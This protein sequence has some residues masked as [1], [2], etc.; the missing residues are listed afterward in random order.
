MPRLGADPVRVSTS[1][2]EFAGFRFDPDRGLDR[3]GRAI[4]LARKEHRLLG[5]LL[6]ARGRVLTKEDIAR[7]VWEGARVSDD[8]IFRAV[9]VLRQTLARES[10]GIDPIAT[11]HGR[12]FR[13]SVPVGTSDAPSSSA[14]AN[15][16]RS[17]VPAAVES[18][19]LALE[20]RG[21]RSPEDMAIAVEAARRAVRID[22]GYVQAWSTLAELHIIDGTRWHEPPR[23]AFAAAAE[24]AARALEIDPDAPAALVA[25][26]FTT[27][28]LRHDFS[29]A[30]E[31]LDRSLE[32]DPSFVTGLT[33]RGYLF[34]CLAR[35]DLGERDLRA[36]LAISPLAPTTHAMLV[37]VLAAR[38][39]LADAIEELRAFAVHS[40]TMDGNMNI[41]AMVTAFGG[42]GDEAV[43][44]GRRAME[45]SPHTSLM[46]LGFLYALIASGRP[47]EAREVA[48]RLRSAEIPAPPSA[49]APA[50]LQLGDRDGAIDA[51]RR[52][53]DARCL[54]YLYSDLDPRL[55]ELATDLS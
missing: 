20:F 49:I 55:S 41:W 46:H 54:Q 40:P 23:T 12:G 14:H 9:Y 10:D 36:A 48:A 32:I 6:A 15:L 16:A 8:S 7:E 3:G 19:V 35:P 37:G 31:Q 29:A 50:L 18:L 33:C 24:A 1:W 22:P 25:S 27:L 26:G 17:A 5:A 38:G 28:L 52:G 4:R 42:I 51:I 13:V 2:F 44:A 11:V 53:R 21:R 39:D 45:T 43:A 47:D 30:L 34:A